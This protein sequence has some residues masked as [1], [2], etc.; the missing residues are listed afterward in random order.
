MELWSNDYWMLD[1]E[2]RAPPS[3]PIVIR[4]HDRA[5]PSIKS[6]FFVFSIKIRGQVSIFNITYKAAFHT[7]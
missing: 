5:W 1:V 2:G 4:G 3:R 6:A 7:C